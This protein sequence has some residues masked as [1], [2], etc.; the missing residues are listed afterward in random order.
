MSDLVAGTLLRFRSA[1][2]WRKHVAPLGRSNV[3]NPELYNAYRQITLGPR[4]P[5]ILCNECQD[6]NA[7]VPDF[8]GATPLAIQ[9]AR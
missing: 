4:P 1:L 5:N 3:D 8:G 9:A 2:H 6:R 7:H